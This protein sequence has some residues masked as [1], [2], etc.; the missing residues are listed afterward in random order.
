MNYSPQYIG[1]LR[2]LRLTPEIQ[3]LIIDQVI[4]AAN[5]VANAA[6]L[7]TVNSSW[8]I[9]VEAMTFRHIS[10]DLEAQGENGADHTITILTPT[11]VRYLKE[12]NIRIEW[13]FYLSA[14][15]GRRFSSAQG[16]EKMKMTIK[17]LA[18]FL[19]T[20]GTIATSSTAHGL[21]LSLQPVKP[22]LVMPSYN[23]TDR[24]L[25][26]RRR[27]GPE[28]HNMWSSSGMLKLSSRQRESLPN[29]SVT[30]LQNFCARL[31]MVTGL[32]FPPDFFPPEAVPALL[33]RFP[34]IRSINLSLM[35]TMGDT[36]SWRTSK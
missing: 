3:Q 31:P 14:Q 21:H 30:L 7:A 25:W 11:R 19:N 8:Q 16:S 29:V 9:L 2:G 5:S 13:P 18:L 28:I 36:D 1:P 15:T 27:K 10:I 23:I 34:N 20:L 26:R 12:L 22:P 35:S 24:G 17:K 33:D 4:L 6:G 32:T